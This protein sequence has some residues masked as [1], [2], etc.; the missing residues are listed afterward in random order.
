MESRQDGKQILLS[1]FSFLEKRQR[2]EFGVVLGILALSAALAQYT[3]LAIGYLTDHVLAAD[4]IPLP[5]VIP[6]LLS[7]LAVNI[8]N[9][10]IKV[11]RRLLVEDTATH[12]EKCARQ[13]ATEALLQAPLVYFRQHMTGN[14]HGRLNRS[15]EG[16]SKLIKLIFMDFAPAVASGVAA[17]AVIFSQLPL[18]VA[19]AIILVI[20]VG[21]FIVLRQITTQ[22]GIR[23]EL[24]NTRAAMDG[25]MVELLGG[26]E[27]IRVL[28][29]AGMEAE[30]IGERSERLRQKEMKHHKAMAFYDCL[31]FINEA[32]FNVLVIAVTV[33]L[34][35]RGE[36]S[37]GTVLTSYLCFTQLTG[38]LR[39]LHRILDEF[40]ESLV[41]AE[42]Y[43]RI[44]G[45]PRDFSYQPALPSPPPRDR[46][47]AAGGQLRL[48]REARRPD[49]AA[50]RSGNPPRQLCGDCRAQRLRQIHPD[51]A[52]CPAGTLYRRHPSGRTAAGEFQPIRAGRAGGPGAPDS[53][54]DCRHRLSQHLLRAA[55]QCQRRGGAGGR[56][57][58]LFGGSH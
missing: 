33:L 35:A 57:P 31:K 28:D 13:R 2:L 6:L 19:L 18:P 22:K 5:T 40:S 25:T 7:I 32:V 26:I 27:T 54:S 52:D 36:I 46:H 1:L 16:T 39:E 37:I 12:V 51:Q 21:T 15:L 42:D 10:V 58:G 50:G 53:L 43:F 17:I 3:P 49:F 47:P 29:S 44:A 55:A 30:R 48:S 4:R 9:E 56:P 23:V 45:I 11:I 20:P 41:L 14:I 24:M 34:A 8:L 38:P